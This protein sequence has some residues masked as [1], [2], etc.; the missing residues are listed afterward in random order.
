MDNNVQSTRYLPKIHFQSTTSVVIH[1]SHREV[2][3]HLQC[4][5]FTKAK[6]ST[7][8]FRLRGIN[9]PR[10][11][12]FNE[13]P[14]CH[15]YKL[16]VEPYQAMHL[17]LIGKFWTFN[18]DLQQFDP[19][20]FKNYPGNNH[21]KAIWEFR[22]LNLG[23]TKTRLQLSTQIFAPTDSIYKRL[24]RYWVFAKPMSYLVKLEIL[25]AFKRQVLRNSA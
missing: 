3:A 8:L 7:L 5:D 21:A 17:G 9:V 12:G 10:G 19:S 14:F 2:F 1:R 20:D 6:M 24:M 4:I 11:D 23:F 16:S 13:N 15:F 22:L 18:G 25:H